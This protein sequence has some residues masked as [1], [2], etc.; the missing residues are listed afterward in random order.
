[1]TT[2]IDYTLL[3]VPALLDFVAR[4]WAEG[5]AA[6]DD[7]CFCDANCRGSTGRI[8]RSHGEVRQTES[9]LHCALCGSTASETPF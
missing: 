4:Q 9:G 3:V 6:A 1:M 5:I 8:L 2:R 7:E